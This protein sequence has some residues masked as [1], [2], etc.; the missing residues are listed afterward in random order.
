MIHTYPRPTHTCQMVENEDDMNRIV[1]HIHETPEGKTL[2][3]AI[4]RTRVGDFFA[5]ELAE[6]LDCDICL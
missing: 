5:W 2:R 6:R 3:Q 1:L 4:V